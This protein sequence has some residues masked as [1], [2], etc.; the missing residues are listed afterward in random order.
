MLAMPSVLFHTSFIFLFRMSYGC[1]PRLGCLFC[2]T[3]VLA[4]NS[5]GYSTTVN[6][7]PEKPRLICVYKT[8]NIYGLASVICMC[9]QI[10]RHRM[11][12]PNL[13]AKRKKKTGI[14]TIPKELVGEDDDV[15][16]V[17]PN[18]RYSSQPMKGNVLPPKHSFPDAPP[19][20]PA[21]KPHFTPCPPKTKKILSHVTRPL[22]FVKPKI[23]SV[24]PHIGTHPGPRVQQQVTRPAP[25]VV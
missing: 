15:T 4:L 21:I 5:V 17:R 24:L 10:P 14:V 16:N 9:E 1:Y 22:P 3:Y 8:A 25:K 13:L 20:A 12:L 19:A 7:E 11:K 2:F 23:R 6:W 18:Y